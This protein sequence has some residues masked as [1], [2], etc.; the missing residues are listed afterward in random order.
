M[1]SLTDNL[2]SRDASAS[3][4]SAFKF[5]GGHSFIPQVEYFVDVKFLARQIL[6]R[7]TYLSTFVS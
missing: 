3:K 2:K 1:A 5:S 4:K 6:D 7:R